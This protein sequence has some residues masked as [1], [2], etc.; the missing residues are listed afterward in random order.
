MAR[1]LLQ[2]FYTEASKSTRQRLNWLKIYGGVRNAGMTDVYTHVSKYSSVA[3]DTS[4][5]RLETG[6]NIE[7]SS[8]VK[9]TIS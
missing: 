4:R 8:H 6:W 5:D 1:L 9:S 3:V 7:N 2:Q